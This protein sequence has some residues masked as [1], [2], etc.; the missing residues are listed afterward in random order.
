MNWIKNGNCNTID[1]VVYVKSGGEELVNVPPTTAYVVQ[2]A[3][4]AASWLLFY[5]A[6]NT[7]INIVGDFDCDGICATRGLKK[8]LVSAGV[9]PDLISVFIPQRSD[10]Y[11]MS[12]LIVDQITDGVIVTVDNGIAANEAIAYA[13]ERG[14]VVIVID[15]H[16]PR[17]ENGQIILPNADLIVD[18]HVPN[19]LIANGPV[20]QC[21]YSEYCAAGLVFKV[22]SYMGLGNADLAEV[23]A[24]A[25][26]ATVADVVNLVGDNRNIYRFGIDAIYKHKINPGLQVVID[27]F[28]SNNIITEGDIGFKIGPL[29]NA[30]ERVQNS[31]AM[32]SFNLLDC[33]SYGKARELFEKAKELNELRKTLKEEEMKKAEAQ[34]QA[35]CMYSDNPIIVH[36]EHEKPG[37]SGLVS[38]EITERYRSSSFCLTE[39]ENNPDVL[40]G[41]ARAQKDEND[42]P[43]DNIKEALDKAQATHP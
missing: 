14:F 42:M 20:V 30:P 11:G 8:A 35:L 28:K 10:G 24:L 27:S 34:I 36:L 17:M 33:Y 18:P 5:G 2:N 26:I 37:L 15:H 23:S 21:T 29:M 9:S 6:N 22:A 38:T 32:I 25:A 43:V 13:K 4:V 19:A 7:H 39:S 16:Q 3:D 12:T 40:V 1:E 41:S 31:G